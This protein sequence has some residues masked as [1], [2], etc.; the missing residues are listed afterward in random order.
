LLDRDNEKKKRL[1]TDVGGKSRIL[2]KRGRIFARGDDVIIFRGGRTTREENFRVSTP[3]QHT[4]RDPC[5]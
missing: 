1:L 3:S 2:S 4:E 5:L